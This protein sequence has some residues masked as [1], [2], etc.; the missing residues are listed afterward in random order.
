MPIGTDAV[1][2]GA[3]AQHPHPTHILDIGTG[4]GI[5]AL[6]LAQRFTNA[7]IDAI[8]ID[9][10]SIT[11]AQNNF[12]QSPHSNRLFAQSADATQFAPTQLYN[13]IVSN[14]PYFTQGQNA[15]ETQRAQARHTL[16]LT[17][18]NLLDTV[19]R[20][21]SPDGIFCCV[22]PTSGIKAFI[23]IAE[24]NGMIVNK[25]THIQYN[26]N[27]PA[28]VSL[29]SFSNTNSPVDIATLL[30]HDANNKPTVEYTQLVSNFYLWA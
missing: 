5:I 2:L 25:I 6:M 27:K 28:T 15:L 29:L 20:L 8:D 14:P 7:I 12:N 13:L 24:N 30:L 11:E 4:S 10:A 1:L 3:W 19:S 22:L 21:L 9:E 17:H 16:T 26:Q 23:L 18:S